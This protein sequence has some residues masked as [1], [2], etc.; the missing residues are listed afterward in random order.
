MGGGFAEWKSADAG[1]GKTTI[2][3]ELTKRYRAPSYFLRASEGRTR[4]DH[5]LNSLSAQLIVRYSLPHTSLPDQAGETSD[6]LY[7]LLKAAAAHQE[8]RPVVVVIDALDEADPT[9]A[10][11]NW[12]HLPSDLPEGVYVILTHRPGNYPL[13]SEADLPVDTF[14]I[15]WD[16]PGQKAD[17]E[18]HLHRQMQRPEIRQAL[19]QAVPPISTDRFMSAL[20][21]A[22]Q[23]NFMFLSY[24]IEDVVQRRSSYVPLQL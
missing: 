9:P 22:S 7:Q 21:D 12:L 19:N 10:G 18:T 15:T 11:H 1:L 2:A 20:L 17:V 5:A 13:T 24:I 8:Y 14:L 16:D 4:A 6:M 3:A 23:G